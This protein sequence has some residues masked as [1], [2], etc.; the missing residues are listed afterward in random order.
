[1]VSAGNQKSLR[2]RVGTGLVTGLLAVISLGPIPGCPCRDSG[3]C[4]PNFLFIEWCCDGNCY[5]CTF[6][7]EPQSPQVRDLTESEKV[8][9]MFGLP[10]PIAQPTSDFEAAINKNAD[11][12]PRD[13][14]VRVLLNLVF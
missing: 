6:A 12:S 14:I 4:P 2:V 5:I 11:S 10:I 13:S 8:L 7:T 3:D 9:R 1:M